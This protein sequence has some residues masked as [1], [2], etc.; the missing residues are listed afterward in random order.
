MGEMSKD[1]KPQLCCILSV[2][3][4][5]FSCNL[6]TTHAK[7]RNGE[8]HL[9]EEMLSLKKEKQEV[10][11]LLFPSLRLYISGVLRSQ[12]DSPILL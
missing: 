4:V 7:I 2:H 5:Q 1:K 8:F 3:K 12:K 11:Q 6:R 10:V 9:R